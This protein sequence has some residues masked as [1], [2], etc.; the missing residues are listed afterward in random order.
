[1]INAGTIE[2][3]QH[4]QIITIPTHQPSH[5]VLHTGFLGS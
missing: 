2:L 5:T 1:M 4:Q 3:F